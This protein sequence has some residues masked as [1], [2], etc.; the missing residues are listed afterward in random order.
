MNLNIY[1]YK[2]F[3]VC[4]LLLFKRYNDCFTFS[5]SMLEKTE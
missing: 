5:K 4:M 1:I 2:S 3:G